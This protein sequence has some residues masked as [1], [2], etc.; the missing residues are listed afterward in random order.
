[1]INI[2]LN[3]YEEGYSEEKMLDLY[4]IYTYLFQQ[5]IFNY[6]SYLIISKILFLNFILINFI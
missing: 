6:Y 3:V 4:S 5:L 1:M 2:I